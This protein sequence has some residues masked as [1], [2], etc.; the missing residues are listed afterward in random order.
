MFKKNRELSTS[1]NTQ[2]YYKEK[3]Y[4]SVNNILK[5]NTNLQSILGGFSTIN[6]NS[7]A[8]KV[9]CFLL[10]LV[11]KGVSNVH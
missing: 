11:G 2:I 8:L 6:Y 3:I 10:N 5:I 7:D 1:W 4:I 9:V